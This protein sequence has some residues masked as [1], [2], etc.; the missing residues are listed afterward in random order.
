[1]H[2]EFLLL[3]PNITVTEQNLADRARYIQRKGVFNAAE[4]ERLR[5]EAAP[6]VEP[7]STEHNAVV[8]QQESVRSE[9]PVDAIAEGAVS[10]KVE[11]MRGIL[12][13]AISEIRS[14]PLEQRPRLSRLPLNAATRGAIEAANR[15]LPSYLD[16]SLGLDDT[17]SILFGAALA[18]HRFIGAKTQEP[19]RTT[20]KSSDVPAWKKRI[21][22]RISLARALI[23]RLQ[24][25]RS[26][27]TRPRI[28]RSVR[29]AFNGLGVRLDQPDIAEKLTE[30]IDGLKQRIAAWGKRIRSWRTRRQ[31][32]LPKNQ[33]R[34]T[35]SPRPVATKE[36]LIIDS[37]A[38]QLVK[39]NRRNFSAAWIDYKKAFDTVPHSWLLRV[40]ELYKIDSAVR[41]F[42][43]VCMGQ[44]STILC[45]QGERLTTGVD[46]R[47]RIRRG[48]FQGD[49]LSPLWFCLSLNPLST[50]LERSGTGFQFRRGGTKVSHLLYMDDLKLLA[51]NPARLMEL[52]KITTEFSGSI[53]MQLGVDK[54]AVVHVDRGQVTQSAEISLELSNFKTLS[55]AE[56][57]R[58]LGMSQC[59]GVQEVDM[60]QAVCEVFFGRLTKV[61]RSYL[62]GANKVRAYNG[63]VMPTLLYTFGLLRWT[64]TE[65]DALDRR[66]EIVGH[67]TVHP[68]E[69]WWPRPIKRQVH[70]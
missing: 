55:E 33:I 14:T 19:G 63:W 66:T 31:A 39:R 27:N 32:L 45:L 43:E 65:L 21:E 7:V 24:S 59:I 69:V 47:I 15:L 3:E 12:E 60:K 36:L 18:V 13:E 68:T 58:Y 62:S 17:G 25:F 1:M 54:C 10:Q 34:L 41:D 22:R 5:R 61:L 20:N 26:G 30:R 70:A 11:Q 53:R 37:V 57:Y 44:W 9:V 2:R 48:I 6:E 40:L 23:G 67:E 28:V 46:D 52:L 16:G 8:M 64:Q 38:G 35:S 56:S 51:P 4:L 50:L 29:I 49:C 42:L